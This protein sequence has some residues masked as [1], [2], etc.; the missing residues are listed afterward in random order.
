MPSEPVSVA[1]LQDYWTYYESLPEGS[2][3]DRS[4]STSEM[5]LWFDICKKLEWRHFPLG[6]FRQKKH[7]FCGVY[8]LVALQSASVWVPARISRLG[9]E[10]RSGTLYIGEAGW[11]HERLGRLHRSCSKGEG[12]HGA[13]KIWRDC[14]LLRTRFPREKLGVAIVRTSARMH[15]KIE[16]DLI[17]AYLNSFGDTPPL[18]CSY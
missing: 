6:R 12:S 15:E 7:G 16:R 8:R 13:G 5:P 14:N 18:N 3:I 1:E 11:L 9:G 2:V 17:R 10:D 4:V